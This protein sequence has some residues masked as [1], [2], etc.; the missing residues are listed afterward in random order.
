MAKPLRSIVEKKLEGV[1]SSTVVDGSTGT[2]GPMVDYKPKDKTSQKFVSLHKTEKHADRVGN[3]SEVYSGSK[4][5]Y[6]LDTPQNKRMGRNEKESVAAQ[7]EETELSEI[8]RE[9]L[10]NYINATRKN[11]SN[12]MKRLD[13][14]VTA[15]D[16]MANDGSAKVNASSKKPTPKTPSSTISN[17][18]VIIKLKQ[19]ANLAMEAVI[20]NNV[21]SVEE[22]KEYIENISWEKILESKKSK[23]SNTNNTDDDNNYEKISSGMVGDSDTGTN[24]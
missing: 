5:K 6:S 12:S 10:T 18:E 15:F 4:I 21:I 9:K 17:E 3:G 23:K 20:E 22:L 14:V 1:K 11:P 24:I 8:S 2:E 19:I 16:K 13:G 7:F